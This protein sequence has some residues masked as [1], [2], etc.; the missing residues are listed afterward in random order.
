MKPLIP[1]KTTGLVE[2]PGSWHID[3]LPPLT[4]MKN[5]PNSHGWVNPRWAAANR[6]QSRCHTNSLVGTSKIFGETTSTI[7]TGSTTSSYSQ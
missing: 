3:D 7:S 5:S 4:F 6:P 2:I 1:G